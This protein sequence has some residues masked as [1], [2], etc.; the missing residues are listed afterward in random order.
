VTPVLISLLVM[1]AVVLMLYFFVFIYGVMP[2][3]RIN[4][5]LADYMAFKLPYKVKA[6]L[7]DE[8]KQLNENI[9]NLI[10]I[11]KSNKKSEGDAL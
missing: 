7:I 3:A 4:R 1:I 6:E 11:S 9:E 10:N 8:F 2:I 5:A